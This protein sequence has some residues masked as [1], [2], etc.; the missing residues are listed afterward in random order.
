MADPFWITDGDKTIV[1]H[2][3]KEYTFALKEFFATGLQVTKDP[4][5]WYVYIGCTLMLL[6]LMVAFFLSHRRIW[7]YIKQEGDAT[8]VL[9]S[10]NANKNRPTFEKN[11]EAVTRSLDEKL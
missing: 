1:K 11:F 6:G 10:G 5:V 4:G 9:I 8:S 2:G 3:G 7:V